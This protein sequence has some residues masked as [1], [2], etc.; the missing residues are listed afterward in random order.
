MPILSPPDQRNADITADFEFVRAF[1]RDITL[2]KF[3]VFGI[4]DFAVGIFIAFLGEAFDDD[5]SDQ[6][7]VFIVARTIGAGAVFIF[8]IEDFDDL[9]VN[10]A[11]ALIN[12][13]D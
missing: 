10:L 7:F 9:A 1:A 2:V 13:D 6:R 12:F 3:A 8:R 5:K 11:V 4:E